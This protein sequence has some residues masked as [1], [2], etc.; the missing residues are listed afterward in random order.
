M[1][2]IAQIKAITPDN[3]RFGF[4]LELVHPEIGKMAEVE[5]PIRYASEARAREVAQ[6]ACDTHKATGKLPNLLAITD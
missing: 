4:E 3:G 2:L 6:M 1:A 5:T